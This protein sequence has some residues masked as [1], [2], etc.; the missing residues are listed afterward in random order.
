M[1][2]AGQFPAPIINAEVDVKP[3]CGSK[4]PILTTGA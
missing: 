2:E 4:S 3:D 1:A